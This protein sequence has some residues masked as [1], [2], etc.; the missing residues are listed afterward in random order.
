MAIVRRFVLPLAVGA[1][2]V[3][4][5]LG[6]LAFVDTTTRP[7]DRAG[8]PF[9][10][11]YIAAGTIMS[12]RLE[13]AADGFDEIALAGG[14]TAGSRPV[15]LGAQLVELGTAGE[16]IAAVRSATLESAAA[17]TACC[18]IRFQPIPDSRRRRYRLDL[19]VGDLNGRQLSLSAVPGPLNGRLTINGRARRAFLIFRTHA[20]AGTG[21]GRLR[22]V[23]AEKSLGLAVLA[24]I[25]NAAIAASVASLTT[26]SDPRRA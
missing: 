6:L 21:F 1:G 7:L 3:A 25:Y 9:Q 10:L 5:E 8:T 2:L 11:R 12:Q 15:A 4:L 23:P 22:R 17:T 20:A 13:V 24:L 18:A 26:A 19:T 16:T 14:I